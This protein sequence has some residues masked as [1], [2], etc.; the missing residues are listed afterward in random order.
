MTDN[1]REFDLGVK[2]FTKSVPTAVRDFRDAVALEGLRG[3]V[4]LTP[5][6]TGRARANWQ[7]T[8]GAPASGE[9]EATDMS[10][11]GET[12]VPVV[13]TVVEGA[14]TVATATDP[15][16]SIWLHNGLSYI[17]YLN[18]GT[19]KIPAAHMLEQ[20]VQRLVRTFSRWKGAK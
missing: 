6:D 10:G 11:R 9:R 7:T 1:F 12:G 4:M 2:T 19:D 16:S 14:A 15:F 20:T 17:G 13:H 8:V 5:V 18:D 3:V